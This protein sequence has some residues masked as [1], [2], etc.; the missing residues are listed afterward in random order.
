[1]AALAR[2]W[3]ADT[4]LH[5]AAACAVRGATESQGE[6][7]VAETPR[8][9]FIL[10]PE[11]S[12]AVYARRVDATAVDALAGGVMVG[13]K[14][15]LRQRAATVD[16]VAGGHTLHPVDVGAN[17]FMPLTQVARSVIVARQ[18]RATAGAV[19]ELYTSTLPVQ[20]QV[21]LDLVRSEDADEEGSPW[22][23]VCHT[24]LSTRL[25]PFAALA[26]PAMPVHSA[27][28]GAA[29]GMHGASQAARPLAAPG[30]VPPTIVSP[31]MTPTSGVTSVRSGSR[32][33]GADVRPLIHITFAPAAHPAAHHVACSETVSMCVPASV[34]CVDLT[35]MLVPTASVSASASQS[36]AVEVGCHRLVW[37]PALA[38][39]AMLRALGCIAPEA[40]DI[41]L[42]EQYTLD[43]ESG[44]SEVAVPSACEQQGIAMLVEAPLALWQAQSEATMQLVQHAVTP[45]V[46]GVAAS[47]TRDAALAAASA[48]SIAARLTT[49]IGGMAVALGAA[50]VLV[51]EPTPASALALAYREWAVKQSAAAGV[52]SSGGT[53]TAGLASSSQA[54]PLRAVH[55]ACVSLPLAS[56]PAYA[57]H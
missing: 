6:W 8:H 22:V 37:P 46:G 16:D 43:A 20:A 17:E 50:C 12:E 54:L 48:L 21:I 47:S 2:Q 51:V 27:K 5:A 3:L 38:M 24:V 39:R 30:A 13:Q 55:S 34:R 23:P 29:R 28:P 26:L 7:H 33:A 32:F 4:A 45:E 57:Q 35:T 19:T 41:V 42:P 15:S 25:P 10:Y 44:V 49:A 56:L 36:W 14:R 40:A 31:A 52:L 11:F 18:P 53:P 1:M 9:R